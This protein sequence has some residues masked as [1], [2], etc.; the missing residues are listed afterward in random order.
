MRLNLAL[1]ALTLVVVAVHFSAGAPAPQRFPH[2]IFQEEGE[3]YDEEV[4]VPVELVYDQGVPMFPRLRRNELDA[5]VE[6][7]DESEN[8]DDDE[9][10]DDD[11][12]KE[13]DKDADDEDSKEKDDDDDD[14]KEKDK[15]DDDDDDDDS[16][17]SKESKDKDDD[18][19][20]DDDDDAD[21]DKEKDKDDDEDDEDKSEEA[22]ESESKKKTPDGSDVVEVASDVPVPIHIPV[23]LGEEDV[24][25]VEANPKTLIEQPS[26]V[27]DDEAE[28]AKRRE[29]FLIFGPNTQY[30]WHGTWEPLFGK[31][32]HGHQQQQHGG[33]KYGHSKEITYHH[34]FYTSLY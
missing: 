26:S 17:E 1:S 33:S 7:N 19:D 15:D 8:E 2:G 24:A 27:E 5:K 20:D 22:S 32:G 11:D 12:S 14:S 23:L 29:R 16:K 6:Q 13:K 21:D 18:D 10:D 9:D 30:G 3:Y 28:D 34:G 31:S 25:H 4:M